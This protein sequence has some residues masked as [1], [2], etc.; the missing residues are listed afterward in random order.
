V[1]VGVLFH[2]DDFLTK[3]KMGALCMMTKYKMGTTES[4]KLHKAEHTTT[5]LS[6]T[7]VF[8]SLSYLW[9]VLTQ[10]YFC[11]TTPITLST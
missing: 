6:I 11:R 3:Y 4:Q 9:P 5:I 1:L 7:L 8:V 2:A 10:E